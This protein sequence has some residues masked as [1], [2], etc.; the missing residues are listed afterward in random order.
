MQK[1]RTVKRE[2]ETSITTYQPAKTTRRK[3]RQIRDERPLLRLFL[4]GLIGAPAPEELV[5][6]FDR[7]TN[8]T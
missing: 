3:S 6:E 1:K 4:L 8:I 7:P 2:V 5:D